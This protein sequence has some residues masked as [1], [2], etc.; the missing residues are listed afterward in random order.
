MAIGVGVK[1]SGSRGIQLQCLTS[2]SPYV[3]L[4]KFRSEI[5]GLRWMRIQHSNRGV[6]DEKKESSDVD[7]QDDS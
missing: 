2:G 5:E 1:E 6:V 3:R 4:H 7:S